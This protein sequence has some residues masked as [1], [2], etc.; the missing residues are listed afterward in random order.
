MPFV[1]LIK[2]VNNNYYY[3]GSTSNVD[4]RLRQHNNGEVR[5]TK[6]RKPYELV[7]IEKYDSIQEARVRERQVKKSRSIKQ[8]ILDKIT[9]PSS[10][11]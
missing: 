3:V 7:Y 11:G 5:S 1:Y 8:G 2:S 4:N 6:F 10:N 9:A